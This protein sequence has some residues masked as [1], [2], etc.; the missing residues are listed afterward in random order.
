M[1]TFFVFLLLVSSACCTSTDPNA[2]KCLVEAIEET[3]F[4]TWR[5][6]SCPPWSAKPR[7]VRTEI[8]GQK[9]C[10]FS[11]HNFA[12]N[13]GISILTTPEQA[14]RFLDVFNKISSDALSHPHGSAPFEQQKIP[15]RGIGL[16]ATRRIGREEIFLNQSP[17]LMIH[18]D[19]YVEFEREDRLPFLNV[20]VQNLPRVSQE[21]F[22]SLARK[23]GSN[24]DRVEDIINTN[25]FEVEV[26]DGKDRT[27][28]GIL[29]PD[30]SVR[31]TN[32]DVF[33]LLISYSG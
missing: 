21:A 29:S 26:F 6:H 18:E 27:S 9:Y 23:S 1:K 24:R 7:C 12:H 10:A 16:V 8:S 5:D 30:I 14:A 17:I 32:L 4:H 22:L 31:L 20:M 15:G 2:G 25:S 11:L 13:R 3:M 19:M 28:Y 33:P